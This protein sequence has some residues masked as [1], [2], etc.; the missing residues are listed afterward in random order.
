[1]PCE[2]SSIHARC[3]LHLLLIP[4]PSIPFLPFPSVAFPALSLMSLHSFPSLSHLL[5]HTLSSLSLLHSFRLCC[6]PYI[7]PIDIADM[8]R[9]INYGGGYHDSQPY[10]E[11][12][13]LSISSLLTALLLYDT[14]STEQTQSFFSPLV[15]GLLGHSVSNDSRGAGRVAAFHHVLPSPAP[16]RIRTAQPPYLR[17][18]RLYCLEGVSG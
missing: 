9:H 13:T 6:R 15:T 14:H 2:L 17:A 10:I 18:G 12:S 1:V 5:P 8:R 4:S 3:N 11:V 7:R 16:Q